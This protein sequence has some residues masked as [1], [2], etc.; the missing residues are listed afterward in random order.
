[1][2]YT[3]DLY[4]S[5]VLFFSIDDKSIENYAKI[6][7]NNLLSSFFYGGIVNMQA[8]EG[9]KVIEVGNILAGPWCGTLMADFGADV[10]KIEPPGTG[11][12][13]R[14][15]G[16]IKDLWY[17]VEGRNKKNITLN[18]KDQKGK[19]I[20]KDLIKDA[21]VLIENFRPGVFKKLGF[22]WEVLEEI[23]P[24]LVYVCSSGYGQTGPESHK[25]GFDRIGFARGGFLEVTGFPGEP[26]VKPGVSACDFY[27]AMFACIGVMFAIYN[28]DVI[29]TGKGQMIDCCLTESSLRIQESIIAE[30]SYDGSIR[31]RIGNGTNVTVPS[32]HFLT[33]DDHYLVLSISGDKLFKIFADITGI[34]ELAENPNYS[35]GSLRTKH[36]DEINNLAAKWA[37][38]HTIK[39]CMTAL[40]DE[41]PNCKVSNVAD[42]MVDEQFRARDAI[43][44]IPTEKFGVISMQNVTPKMMGTPGE[45]KWAGAPLGKFNQE[46]YA[47]LGY[48]AEQIQEME[49][50]GI[51]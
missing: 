40:G 4:F 14:E 43:I 18:L 5:D 45:V 48:T 50:N 11:D 22:S 44:Q 37:R 12:L 35:T 32:G 6:G 46:I 7:A 8:L 25:P 9:L 23:N 49:K 21:D 27:T 13:I 15:M 34:P 29:G 16:R 19:E 47:G 38:E 17:C 42:I 30:Y 39:E 3:L 26:P 20:L 24:R 1:M 33:K 36:R 41:I 31:T 2:H 51:I 28:R 10:I